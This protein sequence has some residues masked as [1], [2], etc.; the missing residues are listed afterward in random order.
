MS[1]IDIIKAFIP[2]IIIVGLLL[3]VL[4]LIKKFG[5][6]FKGNKLTFN[7]YL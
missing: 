6:S 4:L 7:K 1:F 5:G 2:L 3:G